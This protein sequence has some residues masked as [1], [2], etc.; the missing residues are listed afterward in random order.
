MDTQILYSKIASVPAPIRNWLGSD[1]VIDVIDKTEA[2]YTLPRGSS[3]VVANLI[4]RIQIKDLAPDY[5]SGELA[6]ELQLDKDKAVHITGELKKAIFAPRRKDFFDYGIDIDLL[7]KFQMPIIKPLASDNSPKLLQ[8]VSSSSTIS[9]AQSKPLSDVGWSKQSAPQPNVTAKASVSPST[10]PPTTQPAPVPKPTAEPA[11]VMLHQDTTF[12]AAEKNAGFT[13]TQPGG[14][15]VRMGQGA[16]VPTP[17]RPAV[18]EFGGVKP[19]SPAT[20]AGA[21]HYTDFKSP[22]ASTPTANGGSRNVSQIT[23]ATSAT[24][25]P[26]PR[27]PQASISPAPQ[28]PKPTTPPP[29]N[30]PIVKDFL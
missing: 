13:L 5:F 4:Q 28:P 21:V 25:V 9:T 22:L 14:A 1:S 18:L 26:V 2:G 23:G 6:M 24:P 12:K 16:G 29:S 3:G 17:P 7:D 15:N 27:P 19:P 30:K 20:T 8:D 10:P 11:P